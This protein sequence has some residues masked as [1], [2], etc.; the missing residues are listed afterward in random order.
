MGFQFELDVRELTEYV[1]RLEAAAKD[2]TLAGRGVLS[3]YSGLIVREAQRLVPKK[4]WRLHNSIQVGPTSES[5]ATHTARAT[6]QATAPYAGFVEFGTVHMAPRSYMRPAI[7][8]YRGEY[9]KA[10]LKAGTQLL[11]RSGAQQAIRGRQHRF[12]KKA[13]V[14]TA[15][16][17]Q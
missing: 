17:R 10:I 4:T 14:A 12:T 6:V 15:Q 11:T 2:V 5:R 9:Q 1:E 7:A 13:A 8:K 16:R 3:Q